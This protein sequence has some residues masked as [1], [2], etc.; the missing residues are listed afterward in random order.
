MQVILAGFNIDISQIESTQKDA[1]TPET[2]SAAYARISRRP[3]PIPELRKQAAGAVD[4]ARKSN[5]R[6]VF[7]L[8]HASVAEHAVF[9]F[10][11]LD[12]SRLAVETL[13]ARRFASFTEKSQRYVRLERDFLVPEEVLGTRFES[14]FRQ[15][16]ETLFATYR[17]LLERISR[18]YIQTGQARD[19]KMA[20]HRAKEDA[21]YVLPMA[22]FAQLGMTMNARTLEYTIKAL[23]ASRLAEVRRLAHMLHE[24]AFSVAPSLIR[25]T[26][27]SPY[28]IRIRNAAFPVLPVPERAS[29]TDVRLLN[30]T[31]DGDL[32]VLSAM[33]QRVTGRPVL[34]ETLK[35]VPETE[36]AAFVRAVLDGIKAYD[37]MPREFEHAVFTFQAVMSAS[38]FAQMKRHRLVSLSA[39]PY[40]PVLGRTM[41]PVIE[42]ADA[43]SLFERAMEASQSAWQ[44]MQ[45]LGPVADYILTNAH[46]RTVI[47]TMNLRE[48]YHVARL[49]MDKHAQ[50]DIRNISTQLL[51]QVK[52]AFP[53]CSIL[54]AGKDRFDEQYSKAFGKI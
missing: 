16:A 48:A 30:H 21:R 35:N 43:V 34:P 37:P 11:V 2:I 36:L 27:P 9:N 7:G 46:R 4:A 3:E 12:I 38:A 49:R 40:A 6:I 19:E 54:I 10:D 51:R 26:E 52:E 20:V 44:A 15:T 17:A 32:L 14:L 24:P 41:P 45:A 47:G 8:G 22:T 53:L 25:Y 39:G 13:E 42:A 18:Y 33:A 50:W 1:L 23:A 5:E 28:D 29:D 31:T